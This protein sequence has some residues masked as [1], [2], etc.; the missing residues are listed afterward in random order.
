MANAV[1]VKGYRETMQALHKVNRGVEK[2]WRDAFKKAAEPIAASARQK[3]GRYSGASISTIGPKVSVSGVF[4]TQ[5]ARKVTGLRADFGAL[6]MTQALIP[7]LDEHENDV[8]RGVER[9]F[10]DLAKSAGF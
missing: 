3:L 5:R 1:R 9:S 7:A 6:Q 10:D 4:V 8:V 2:S